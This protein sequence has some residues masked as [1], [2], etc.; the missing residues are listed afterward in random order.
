MNDR[1]VFGYFISIAFTARTLL[2]LFS[3]DWW[4]GVPYILGIL[5]GGWLTLKGKPLRSVAKYVIVVSFLSV[6]GSFGIKYLIIYLVAIFLLGSP[7]S[8]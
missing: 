4:L 3:R 6:I 2:S 7:G 8:P 5:F 1:T